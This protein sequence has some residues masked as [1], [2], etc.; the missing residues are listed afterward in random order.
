M[1]DLITLFQDSHAPCDCRAGQVIG[2]QS[3]GTPCF[4]VRSS[5]KE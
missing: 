1:I 5:F 3:A 2:M 4:G